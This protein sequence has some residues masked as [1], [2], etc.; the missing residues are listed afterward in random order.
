MAGL[1][2]SLFFATQCSLLSRISLPIT[3]GGDG[4]DIDDKNTT[5]VT[6]TD[7]VTGVVTETVTVTESG[8]RVTVTV[9]EPD[10]SET[11]TVTEPGGR[12]TV[13]VTEPDGRETVTVTEPDGRETVTVT[14][15]GGRETVT[16]R[17][18]R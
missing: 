10:G 17:A 5:R 18:G 1:C 3:G 14:E 4:T 7:P 2:F 6:V 13:T 15:P 16:N 8:G 12:E 11:V 9:T